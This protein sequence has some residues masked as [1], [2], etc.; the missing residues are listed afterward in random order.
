MDIPNKRI[1]FISFET[2]ANLAFDLLGN[3]FKTFDVMQYSVW[4][5]MG[6]LSK[7]NLARK[8]DFIH[9]FW[10]KNSY[11]D[12]IA[13]KLTGTKYINHYIGSDVLKALDSRKS[14][15]KAKKIYKNSYKTLADADNL[16]EELKELKIND[17]ELLSIY[18]Y[19]KSDES[20]IVTPPDTKK[21]MTYIPEGKEDFYGFNFI[22]KAAI[23]FPQ[24]EFQ[25]SANEGKY[26]NM[27]SNVS[28]LGW[29]T[30]INKYIDECFLYIRSTKHDGLPTSV[31]QALVKGKH[32]LSSH[33]VPFTHEV[34]LDNIEKCLAKDKMNHEGRKYILDNYSKEKVIQ[35]FKELYQ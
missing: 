29:V 11:N 17:V 6:L 23:K 22:I 31:M 24:Y 33:K 18:F 21:I 3:K 16:I 9:S 32:V 13:C 10:A 34:N 30:D 5:K 12:I 4:N 27:P 25:I 1:L 28:F 20:Y 26:D 19:D 14:Q 2:F 15:K 35:K 8:Y 7:I